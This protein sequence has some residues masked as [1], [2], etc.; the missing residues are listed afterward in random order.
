MVG[1]TRALSTRPGPAVFRRRRLGAAVG[2]VL[3]FVCCWIALQ[4]ALGASGGGTLTTTGAPVG[5]QPA[6]YRVWVV[7]PGDTLWSIA[8]ATGAKGDIRPFVDRLSAEV[9]DRPLQVGQQIEVP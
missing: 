1:D 5:A 3:A 9:G 8:E 2:L 6:S 4:A 7:R